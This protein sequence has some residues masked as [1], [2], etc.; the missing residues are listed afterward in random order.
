MSDD[1]G[2][3]ELAF[4]WAGRL[5]DGTVGEEEI[6]L[7]RAQVPFLLQAMYEPLEEG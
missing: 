7:L 1:D 4:L 3:I 6:E 5:L 2:D